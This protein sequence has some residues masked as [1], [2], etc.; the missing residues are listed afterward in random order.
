MVRSRE[1]S[2]RDQLRHRWLCI[3]PNDSVFMNR[4]LRDV[5]GAFSSPAILLIALSAPAVC[6]AQNM[7]RGD[8]AHTGVLAGPAPRQFHPVKW[9]FATGDRIVSSPVSHH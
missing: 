7:F 1:S 2:V 3:A 9:R 8:A 4:C 6:K 5:A